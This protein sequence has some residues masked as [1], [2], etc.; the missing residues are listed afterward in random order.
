MILLIDNYDSFTFNLVD[1]FCQLGVECDVVKN[2][3]SPDKYLDKKY[4]A[5]V[6][7]PGPGVPKNAGYLLKVIEKTYRKTPILGICL[8]HEAICEY[9]GGKLE[10][11]IKPMHGK[12]SKIQC[13]KTSIFR[14]LPEYINV[15]RYHS[16]VCR[17][18]PDQLKTIA[19]T[20]EMEIMGV[21]HVSLPIWGVQFHP[22]A[23]LTEFGLEILKNW[24]EASGKTN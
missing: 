24:L 18:L 14:G 19:L 12:V 8:G 3:I 16:L 22:E 7:S 6:I 13:A 5:V 21:Q 1:Y 15:V 23:A 17:D 20:E 4:D 10:R 11:A 2:D 9:F